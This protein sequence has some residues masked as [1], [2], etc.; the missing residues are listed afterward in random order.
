[1]TYLNDE[2][3][4]EAGWDRFAEDNNSEDFAGWAGWRVGVEAGGRRG[5]AL[6]DD[7]EPGEE[8]GHDVAGVA[9]KVN[10]KMV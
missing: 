9:L 6:A 5:S 10:L 1:M 2:A 3:E 7:A 8:V 4:V